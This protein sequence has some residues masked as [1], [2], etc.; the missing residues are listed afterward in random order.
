MNRRKTMSTTDT[1]NGLIAGLVMLAIGGLLALYGVVT[2]RHGK[3]VAAAYP[4]AQELVRKVRTRKGEPDQYG[5]S[6][7]T[8]KVDLEYTVDGITYKKNRMKSKTYLEGLV[9]VYY[10]PDNP[11]KVYTEDYAQGEYVGGWY[12]FGG[13]VGG[14]GLAVIVYVFTQMGKPGAL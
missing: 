11:K 14:L 6:D 1:Q 12:L 3:K 2:G 9:T 8:F 5:D 4:T 13:I 7:T 10:N